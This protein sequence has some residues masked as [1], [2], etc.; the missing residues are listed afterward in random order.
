[1]VGSISKLQSRRSYFHIIKPQLLGSRLGSKQRGKVYKFTVR[2]D[3]MSDNYFWNRCSNCSKKFLR[4]IHQTKGDKRVLLRR[5]TKFKKHTWSH[6]A[7]C[8]MS[9]V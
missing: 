8:P 3:G 4:F 7:I 1:M 2:S 6:F 5:R 9:T